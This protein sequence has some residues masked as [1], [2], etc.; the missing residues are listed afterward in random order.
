M[1]QA[2][3]KSNQANQ[4]KQPTS[5]EQTDLFGHTGTSENSLLKRFAKPFYIDRNT[6]FKLSYSQSE[7]IIRK[8]AP[9]N[10]NE[11]SDNV[12]QDKKNKDVKKK[13]KTIQQHSNTFKLKR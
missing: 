8:R 6:P 9:A 7:Q 4:R 13:S 10:Y 1:D 3:V 12:K 5:K 2:G 11:K